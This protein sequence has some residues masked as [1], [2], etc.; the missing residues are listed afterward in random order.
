MVV[1]IAVKEGINSPLSVGLFHSIRRLEFALT[2]TGCY[3]A[4]VLSKIVW[5]VMVMQEV[6]SRWALD[7][8]FEEGWR[9]SRS[10]LGLVGTRVGL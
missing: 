10:D 9:M 1:R 8:A 5:I 4:E 3:S 6:R 7:L 2:M